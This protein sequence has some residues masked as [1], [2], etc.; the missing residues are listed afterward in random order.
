ME[1]DDGL[2]NKQDEIKETVTMSSTDETIVSS[3][4][5]PK[6]TQVQIDNQDKPKKKSHA[7]VIGMVFLTILAIGGIGFGIWAWTTGFAQNMK[8]EEEIMDLRS[9]LA[10]ATQPVEED[11]TEEEEIKTDCEEKNEDVDTA[12]YI[13]VGEWG[14]KIKIPDDLANLSYEYLDDGYQRTCRTLG[15]SASTV[16]DGTKP[17][18]VKTGSEKG[19]YLG[20]VSRC[21]KNDKYPYGAAIPIEDTKY[22]Y[23]YDR[24]QYSITQTDWEAESVHAI[25]TMLTTSENYSD[26]FSEI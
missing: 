23:Y 3:T 16:R 17:A 20:Y 26:I 18:F 14:L 13:Y 4:E 25:E 24:I 15:V 5:M 6:P 8:H 1:P 11:T 19:D 2:N 12:D 7:M 21:P 10:E 9:Q 22:D